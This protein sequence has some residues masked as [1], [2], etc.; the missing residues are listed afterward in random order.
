MKGDI[1][2]ADNWKF[3]DQ[4][5]TVSKIRVA[6]KYSLPTS[7]Q[8]ELNDNQEDYSSLYHEE[9]CDLISTIHVK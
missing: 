3:R 5:F 8:D 4:E 6:I 9:W 7:M 1:Y 2:E